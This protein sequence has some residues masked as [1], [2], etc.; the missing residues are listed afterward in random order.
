MS[1][2]SL[3]V[4]N[5]CNVLVKRPCHLT[6]RYGISN[7]LIS[8]Y[9]VIVYLDL[10]IFT[11]SQRPHCN[12]T[13]NDWFIV[14][15]LVGAPT[16]VSYP[17]K[18]CPIHSAPNAFTGHNLHVHQ[19]SQ[20]FYNIQVQFYAWIYPLHIYHSILSL[21]FSRSRTTAIAVSLKGSALLLL[22]LTSPQPSTQLIMKFCVTDCPPGLV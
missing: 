5:T 10:H 14:D 13:A 7:I 17:W 22:F 21:P 12:E 6:W 15:N 4:K 2:A 1:I 20:T 9:T 11:T 16:S 3:D 19:N 18:E 8:V